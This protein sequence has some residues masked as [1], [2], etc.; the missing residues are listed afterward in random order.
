MAKGKPSFPPEGR[1]D[2][3]ERPRGPA[4]LVAGALALLS[5]FL[6]V[7][8]RFLPP[9]AA[10]DRE[11]VST[12][13]SGSVTVWVARDGILIA[14]VGAPAEA[15]AHPPLLVPLH[16]HRAAVLL[17][18]V[19]WADPAGGAATRLD[20]ELS[21]LYAHV[22]E[23]GAAPRDNVETSDLE[24]LGMLLLE[25]LRS[26]AARIFDRI[27]LGPDEPLLELVLAGYVEGYGPEVWTLRYRAV[28][29]QLRGD[30]Y[31]TRVLRPAYTQHYPPEKGQPR[32][33][34]EIRYPAGDGAPA[35]GELFARNDPRVAGLRNAAVAQMLAGNAHRVKIEEAEP[36][37]RAALRAAL[38]PG[39]P[40][41]LAVITEERGFAWLIEPPEAFEKVESEQAERDREPGAPTLR[42]RPAPRPPN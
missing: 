5:V 10:Q 25:P 18:A 20:V 39:A 11:V 34:I 4:G 26:S 12:L 31:R 37:L 24:T 17:G 35:P 16:R 42:R 29:D 13:A 19:E 7:H 36:V 30:Y 15:G 6:G 9:G 8:P 32:R 40:H 41:A 1:H 33:L 23:P 14:L 22:Q 28:Q 2:C 3:G 27:E 21:R 38:E